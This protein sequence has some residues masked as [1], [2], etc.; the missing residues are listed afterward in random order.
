MNL[1][2]QTMEHWIERSKQILLMAFPADSRA[3]RHAT[4][5]ANKV[6]DRLKP[7]AYLHDTIEDHPEK[8]SIEMLR[9][10]GFPSYVVDAVNLLTHQDGDSNNVYWAKIAPNPDAKAVKLADIDDNLSDQP[11]EYAKKKYA[12]ALVFF[13]AT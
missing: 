13:G 5:I 9:Q 7:I 3:V 6:E 2:D 4:R 12:R 8:V 1:A 11:S 10:E